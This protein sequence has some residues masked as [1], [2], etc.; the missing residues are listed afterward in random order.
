MLAREPGHSATV[1]VA[2]AGIGS[3]PVNI[4]AGNEKKLPPPATEF[5]IP[6]SVA[7]ENNNAS[8]DR[9][10]VSGCS[11]VAPS[12]E[13]ETARGKPGRMVLGATARMVVAAPRQSQTA[14]DP[15]VDY[16]LSMLCFAASYSSGVFMLSK[17]LGGK[18]ARATSL[19]GITQQ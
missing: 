14:C 7:A 17:T 10:I 4:S 5:S 19:Q 13:S 15:I 1:D 6:A 11:E 12:S 3:T 8:W 2:F 18:P 16:A 9:V